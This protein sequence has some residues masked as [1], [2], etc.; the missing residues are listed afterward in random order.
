MTSIGECA[1]SG[2]SGPTLIEIPNSVTSIGNRAF[3]ECSNL[4]AVSI[5]NS[6]TSIGNGAFFDCPNL[7]SIT[8]PNSVTSIGE[9]AFLNCSSLTSVTV[10]INTPL[11]ITS[12]TFSNRAN[13]TLY[14][15]A[16]C[17]SAYE[18]ADYWKEF[19]EIVE[20]VENV[21]ITIGS[22][23]MGTYCS[24]YDLDFSGVSGIR[25]YIASGFKPSTGM[26]FIMRVEEVPANTGIMVKGTPGTYTIPVKE[27]DM[28]YK[29]M[30]KG[31]LVSMTVPAIEDGCQ[32]YVLRS[33][34]YGVKFYVSHG[35]STL[36]ANKA[37]L[38]IPTS[39]MGAR[40]YINFE[41][42][43]VTGIVG[44]EYMT[45]EDHGELYNLNGQR[46]TN[47]KRGIYIKNGKKIM[48]RK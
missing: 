2:C 11:A 47:P 44:P 9:A 28:Y 35:S 6:V 19:K 36:G 10:D 8:I 16:G 37:Y 40:E 45:Q 17:K 15:P 7:T 20:I 26:A 27:T 43:N 3:E 14:V 38:Q 34:D 4:T 30:F 13:A 25:A 12:N 18:A 39:I 48:I 41:E 29:N 1:F 23:G 5:P 46:I 42:D 33:G 22:L 21:T 31:T 24:Q 32:N